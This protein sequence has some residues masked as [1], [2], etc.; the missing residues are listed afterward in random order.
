MEH[1]VTYY[2]HLLNA[3]GNCTDVAT[4]REP[5]LND[6]P[7]AWTE[8]HLQ[9]VWYDPALRPPNLRDTETNEP[10]EVVEPGTWNLE[11]GPDFLNAVIRVG[12]DPR[13]FRGDVEIHVHPRDWSGHRHHGNPL[14]QNIIAHVTYFPGPRPATLPAPA[15]CVALSQPLSEVPGFSLDAVDVAPYPHA[16]IPPTPRPCAET[17]R[18]L[19][20]SNAGRLLDAA[21]CHRLSAKVA[22]FLERLRHDTPARLFHEDFFAA[23]GYKNNE[24]SFRL[25]ARLYPP[26]AWPD[27]PR[28]LHLA[29]LLGLARLLP[30]PDASQDPETR[31][32]LRRLWDYW[33]AN[34]P[35]AEWPRLAWDHSGRPQNAPFRRLAAAVALAS[36]RPSLRERLAALDIATFTT[37]QWIRDAAR[38]FAAPEPWPEIESRL[39]LALPASAPTALLGAGRVAAILNNVLLPARLAETPLP[40]DAIPVL[41]P[42]TLSA[43]MRE[44]ARRLFGPGHD[45]ALYAASGLR[46]QGLL[47]IW[48]NFC[49]ATRSGCETCKLPAR[50]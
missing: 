13:V 29:K 48:H 12:R 25:L 32:L 4:V 11:P 27:A 38:L 41:P 31:A 28:E 17:L 36:A 15:H 50:L 46:Q 24:A 6:A 19:P 22:R 37:R 39:S 42:E 47:Q 16:A 5:S 49:L 10:V 3:C 26:D 7:R 34:T 21:G 40:A 1:L 18:R 20:A 30:P 14:Y 23:L 45:P 8:R 9:C 2:A 33:W 35:D 44:T 43:P